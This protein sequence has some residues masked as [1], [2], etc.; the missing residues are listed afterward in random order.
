MLTQLAVWR[1]GAARARGAP[2]GSR[3]ARRAGRQLVYELSAAHRGC[4]LLNYAIQKVLRAG[5]EGEVAGV[6]ASLA[7][8]F[9]VFQRLMANRLR[10][11][12]DAGPARLAGLATELQARGSR[13]QGSDRVSH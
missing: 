13:G 1:L 11:V 8:Y 2:H 10:E 9:G 4:L 5:H 12:P 3:R 6:G 7:S